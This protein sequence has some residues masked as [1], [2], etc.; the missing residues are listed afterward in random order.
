MDLRD[1]L[2]FWLLLSSYI[3]MIVRGTS[4]LS[5]PRALDNGLYYVK[6]FG[7]TEL[8]PE[9]YLDT[10]TADGKC[11]QRNVPD[12]Y[13]ELE[14]IE[15][16]G[17]QYIDTGYVPNTTTRVVASIAFPETSNTA[18][19]WGSRSS[20]AYNTSLDQ[21]Y[22]GHTGTNLWYYSAT[23]QTT[24]RTGISPNVFYD[25]DVTNTRVTATATQNIYLFALNNLGTATTDSSSKIAKFKIYDN[26]ILV[27]NF[28]PCKNASGVIGMYDTV[29]QTFFA[30]QG[31]GTFLA[32]PLVGK[33]PSGY[34]R[35]Q[36]T[37]MTE[38]SYLLT[39][40]VPQ[41]D[42]RIEVDF[43]T[44]SFPS[45]STSLFGTRPSTSAGSGIQLGLGT[46]GQFALDGLGARYNPTT[47]ATINTRYKYVWN[48]KNVTLTSGS[49]TIGSYT[50][51]GE[52]TQTY[53]LVFN[54]LNNAGTASGGKAGIYLYSFKAWNAQGELIA[55]YIPCV[56]L[57]PLTIGL[58]DSV[59]GNFLTATA[60]T[61]NSGPAVHSDY[62]PTPEAPL[63]I[64]CNNGVMKVRHQS[65]LPLG[66]TLLD[67][68]ESTGTQYINTGITDVTNSEFEVVA[69]QTSITGAFPTIMGALDGESGYKVVCGLSTSNNTFYSQCGGPQGFI[70]SSVPNDTQKHTFKVTTTTN[71]QT[72]QVDDTAV[73]TGNYAITSTTGYSLTICARNKDTVSNFTRQKVFSVRIKKSGVLI[74]DFVP[75]KRNS[76]NVLGMYDLV[77]GQF[78]T[79]AGTG[80]FTAGA[81]VNDI[82]IYTDGTVETITD[83]D[84]NTATCQNL[85][86]VGT[87][88]DTQEVIS[89]A[90]T[91]NVGIKVLDGTESWTAYNDGVYFSL[92]GGGTLPE[93]TVAYCTHFGYA[94]AGFLIAN[95]PMNE[96]TIATNGNCS[97]KSNDTATKADWVAWLKSQYDAGTPVIV[98]YPLATATTESVA[99]QTLLK[100]PLTV[101][102]SIDN[103]T[104]TPVSSTHTVPTPTQPLDIRCNNG[105]L[106]TLPAGYTQLE[107]I[108]S[109]GA[110]YINT[111]IKANS[112]Y[113]YK[114]KVKRSSPYQ[115]N[116]WGIKEASSYAAAPCLILGYNG[117][118]K[119]SLY[120][121]DSTGAGSQDTTY[122]WGTDFHTITF[123]ATKSLFILDGH[124][125]WAEFASNT[126]NLTNANWSSNLDIFLGGTNTIGSFAS[127][128]ISGWAEYEVW[129][130]PTLLQRLIPCKN[131]SNVIGMYDLVSGQF[132]TNQGTGT[133]TAGPTVA[134]DV[135]ATGPVETLQMIGK[136]LFD[137]Q[138]RAGIYDT[139]SGNYT[140]T[141]PNRVCNTNIIAINP[142]TVYTVSCPDYALASGMRWLFYDADK[143]FISSNTTGATS[144][145]TPS[146]A[147]YLNF[148]I[149]NNLTTVTAPDLQL[150]V[151]STATEY[152]AYYNG[153]TATCEDLLSV[154]TYTDEQEVLSGDVTRNVG[155]K[156]LDGTED[157]IF[158]YGMVKVS[159]RLP[160][161]KNSG[162]QAR[163]LCSH[164]VAG[165]ASANNNMIEVDGSAIWFGG[166]IIADMGWTTAEDGKAWLAQQYAAGTPVIV[167][168]PLATPTTESVA[169]QTMQ[170][171]EGD[172]YI[173]ITQ[174]SMAGLELEA[175]YKKGA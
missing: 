14:Y 116:I 12:R 146:T 78:F 88:K 111:G 30:N 45:I 49:T 159:V 21:F 153:G 63:D 128:G 26:G 122:E 86:S 114:F 38:G 82:E 89:G 65:G 113:T 40:I 99:G 87:Y 96:F 69:Q 67:Y 81:T 109:S 138:Y 83:A 147:R 46:T 164:G 90:I 127:A 3:D 72:L 80:T 43:A 158:Q 13:T 28:I 58:Y 156:V 154:G 168:Y 60:G 126:T 20:G 107:Y 141:A 18:L 35:M 102:G 44:T 1:K 74:R 34:D 148:Y 66:Y 175:K 7:G 136:N 167:V 61:W 123:N 71:Q 52:Q 48:N 93:T 77:S 120:C 137:G 129:N 2:K 112:A 155:I 101:T 25:I 152:E 59:S 161:E 50:F 39:D 10:V 108:Q 32:G 75:V 27:R 172:N 55:D 163:R 151:G 36:F 125:V 91:H 171:H 117:T 149:A 73:V 160:V 53:P 47:L 56:K 57:Q 41:G 37:Y 5:L 134:T 157:A 95:L 169:G 104:V 24:I 145:T 85:L 19:C 54:G 144:V 119:I 162:W 8:V 16:T 51:T 15:S 130:G 9:T 170:V 103:L 42:Y 98:I 84:S 100:E 131:S 76:D 150:E 92:G 143:N 173:E 105:V 142:S 70:V 106:K 68:I 94:G 139:V 165:P 110:Q 97:F 62:T 140:P 29:S 6:A 124:D 121:H 31:T 132:F 166:K 135:I 64:W 22:C 33:L 11:E 23:T 118:N 115:S 133:F 17:T 174:A 4:P 79:N